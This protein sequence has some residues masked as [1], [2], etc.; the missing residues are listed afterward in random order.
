VAPALLELMP[1][2]PLE[3]VAVEQVVQANVE[4]Y[5][6]KYHE[7][8]HWI[9]DPVPWAAIDAL[10]PRE[11]GRVDLQARTIRTLLDGDL[12]DFCD[13]S[14]GSG[15]QALPLLDRAGSAVLCELSVDD[16]N[17]VHARVASRPHTL[18]VRCDY[19]Q[20]PFLPESFDT[21]LC[22]DTLIYG[23]DHE[24]RLLRNLYSMLRPQ[25]RLLADFKCKWHTNPLRGPYMVDYSWREVR[26]LVEGAGFRR[27]RRMGYYQEDLLL[28]PWLVR[29]L[30]PPTRYFVLMEK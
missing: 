13:I 18:L 10:S 7:P 28:P 9:Q 17:F 2:R 4:R 3:R 27:F 14:V 21:I 5:L 1:T 30:V 23:R 15:R 22:T 24:Q 12:G 20:S 26:D 16:L 11:R 6:R 25:G 8:F 19:L 29:L